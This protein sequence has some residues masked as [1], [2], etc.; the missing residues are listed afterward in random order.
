MS[1]WPIL[2]HVL[3][4]TVLLLYPNGFCAIQHQIILTNTT[5]VSDPD[6]GNISVTMKDSKLSFRCYVLH[7]IQNGIISAELNVKYTEFGTYTN[8]FKKRINFCELM[9]NPSLD[10]LIYLAF[11][12]VSLDQRNHV[13]AKCPITA[14]INTI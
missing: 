9:D 4:L 6:L 14:V 13:F 7:T 12:T 8:F 10:T 2:S 1:P 3:V 11:K 5:G